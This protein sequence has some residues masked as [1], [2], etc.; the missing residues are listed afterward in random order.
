GV[1]ND[2][3]PGAAPPLD[4]IGQDQRDRH[5]GH[6]DLPREGGVEQQPQESIHQ[7]G[8]PPRRPPPAAAAR[9]L[10]IYTERDFEPLS[11]VEYSHVNTSRSKR[12]G[13]NLRHRRLDWLVRVVIGPRSGGGRGRGRKRGRGRRQRRFTLRRRRRRG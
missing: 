1:D 7:P 2:T 10:S 11:V 6:Q 3:D 12:I 8:P 4:N 9:Q 5:K 13:Q